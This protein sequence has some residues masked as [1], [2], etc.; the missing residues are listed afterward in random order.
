MDRSE[1]PFVVGFVPSC[2]S[3]S[4]FIFFFFLWVRGC[5]VGGGGKEHHV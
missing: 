4:F 3:L 2:L 5:V 1:G